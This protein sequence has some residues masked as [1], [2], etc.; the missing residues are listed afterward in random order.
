MST[1]LAFIRPPSAER[2][3]LTDE[4]NNKVKTGGGDSLKA[5]LGRGRLPV[6]AALMHV[7]FA[8]FNAAVFCSLPG[9]LNPR[10]AGP[11]D[12]PPPAGGGAFERPPHDLG[13]WSP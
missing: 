9:Q 2:P 6:S 10:P 3:P 12:F 11:L 1:R 8:A 7:H 5:S 4:V 13:S